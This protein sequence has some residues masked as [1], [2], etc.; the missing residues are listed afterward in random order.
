MKTVA[1][2]G[3]IFLAAGAAA[4][5]IVSE[6]P[7][8]DPPLPAPS[9]RETALAA[10]LGRAR[11]YA[12]RLERIVHRQVSRAERLERSVARTRRVARRALGTSPIGN[13]W[14]ESAFLCIRGFEGG[15]R[16][17]AAPYWGGLQMDLDF[18]RAYG[19]EF[20]AA[21]GTADNW[22]RSVQLAVGIRGYLSRGFNPW[23]TTRRFCGL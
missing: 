7:A 12:R 18:Q 6:T 3:F 19:R 10:Q 13:H 23:P 5:L 17:P 21:F 9:A 8:Q 11:R 16:D 4:A 15:W 1:A 22:P 20:L 2:L 14:L